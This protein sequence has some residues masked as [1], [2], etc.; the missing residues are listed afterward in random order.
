MSSIDVFL[1]STSIKEYVS[2]VSVTFSENR[3]CNELNL[4]LNDDFFYTQIAGDFFGATTNYLPSSKRIEV[5]TGNGLTADT[6]QGTFFIERPSI[7]IDKSGSQS[8]IP[9]SIWGR[10]GL[11]VLDNPFAPP[12]FLDIENLWGLQ[13]VDASTLIEYIADLYNVT[14]YQFDIDDFK[15][16]SS[17]QLES[18]PLD[19][20]SRIAKATNGYVRSTKDG[21][22]WIKK[23]EFHNW[24]SSSET[25]EE[26]DIIGSIENNPELPDFT[27]RITF[28]TVAYD[29][30]NI[31]LSL[32]ANP[33][34]IDANGST[35]ALE[36]VVTDRDGAPVANGTIVNWTID[37]SSLG[38]FSSSTT[39]TGDKTVSSEEQTASSHNKVSVDYPIKSVSSVTLLDG[40]GSY[41]GVGGSFQGR[42]ITLDIDLPYNDSGVLVSYTASGIATNTL[43]AT[44]TGSG[45]NQESDIHAIVDKMRDSSSITFKVPGFTSS[46][47]NAVTI[48]VKDR[49]TGDTIA[50]AAVRVDGHNR[51]TTNG[52]G[53][54]S[55]GILSSGSHSIEITKIGYRDS[56]SDGLS[57]DYFSV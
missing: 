40:S 47:D 19:I 42:S 53:A 41:Y 54:I 35:S 28:L 32:S 31:N 3:P 21:Q 6:S 43:T 22:I 2:D 46:P 45:D 15:I 30:Q 17:W 4:S 7:T 52:S 11:A 51:G 50:G 34:S 23:H 24:G 10:N 26:T 5:K 39:E 55:L 48:V 44:T 25:I 57:N 18:Y 49:I 1:D 27:N 29:L 12:L 37:N 36:V 20:I 13:E 9:N 38:S 16:Y 56:V 33:S 8:S 14:V